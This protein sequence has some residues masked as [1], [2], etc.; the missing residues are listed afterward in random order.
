MIFESFLILKCFKYIGID[1]EP[2]KCLSFVVL[3]LL[4]GIIQIIDKRCPLLH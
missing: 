4:E 3:I 2:L 1:Q